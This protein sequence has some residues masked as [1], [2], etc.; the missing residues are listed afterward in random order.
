MDSFFTLISNN[1]LNYVS[2]GN[3]K[4][5]QIERMV[6]KYAKR[7]DRW[8]PLLP[9]ERNGKKIAVVVSPWKET[10]VPLFSVECAFAM[11]AEGMDVTILW[12]VSQLFLGD[13]APRE[14]RALEDLLW[15]IQEIFPIKDISEIKALEFFEKPDICKK[16][17]NN[18]AI[19]RAKGET[20]AQGF[21]ELH[22][23]I[24]KR[25]VKH[26]QRIE[27][28][29][30]A[31]APDWIF[32]PGGVFSTSAMY[33]AGAKIAGIRAGT[34]DSDEGLLFISTNEVAT[35]HADI[36][37]SD[38]LFKA[39][40]QKNPPAS[41]IVETA[42]A[43]ELFNRTQSLDSWGFQVVPTRGTEA[44]KC[45]VLVPLNLRWDTAALSR[46]RL[47][48]NVRAWIES[49]VR[50][51]VK[52][53]E[54]QVC[55]RQ[56]PCERHSFARGSD[57]MEGWVALLAGA[58]SNI[59]FVKA[60]DEVNTYDLLKSCKVL[61]PYTS[62][63]GLEACLLGIPSILSTEC[64][65]HGYGFTQA[66]VTE[67]EF[68]A[69][70]ESALKGIFGLTPDAKSNACRLYFLGQLA[71]PVSTNFTPIPRDFWK[72]VETEPEEMWAQSEMSDILQ[73]FKR[74]VPLSFLR[75][76]RLCIE[77]SGEN[78]K[79]ASN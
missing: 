14:K 56:H 40:L 50:W 4:L 41:E 52:H 11:V 8:K 12:D 78:S 24:L 53:P 45:D 28:A 71:A 54:W 59:R 43:S 47:F 5:S 35:H 33:L 16:I 76:K 39:W 18:N 63:M 36:R 60:T 37:A 48:S 31:A 7:I 9:C 15:K 66:P 49:I 10:A 62:T 27:S 30:V 77:L 79:H 20:A 38:L 26:L 51:A 29:I 22:P 57:D 55:F 23:G 72:W 17:L 65:Y 42:V 25:A 69:G 64:Y 13:A 68:H 3:K 2:G 67:S 70:I 58:S 6:A 73:C 21:L 75:A 19:A 34:F 74:E 61:V 1:I 32:V 44:F 46:E